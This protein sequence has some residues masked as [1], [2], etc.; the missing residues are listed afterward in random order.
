MQLI[1]TYK[2]VINHQLGYA[3]CGR[4]HLME[5]ANL[6]RLKKFIFPLLDNLEIG[7]EIPDELMDLSF[8]DCWIDLS[9]TCNKKTHALVLLVRNKK[10]KFASK[11]PVDQFFTDQSEENADGYYDFMTDFD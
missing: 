1:K 2:A 4:E 6:K 8:D 7:K 9:Y 11:A 3:V 5:Y 10:L